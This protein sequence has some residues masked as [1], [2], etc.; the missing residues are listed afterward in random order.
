VNLKNLSRANEIAKIL[1]DK[2]FPLRIRMWFDWKHAYMCGAADGAKY[3]LDSL[4][5]QGGANE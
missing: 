5:N 3:V 1:R 2:L 4:D